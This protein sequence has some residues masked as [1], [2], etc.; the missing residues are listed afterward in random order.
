MIIFH[1]Q[2]KTIGWNKIANYVKGRCQKIDR[3]LPIVGMETC[4]IVQYYT[5]WWYIYPSEKYE[6]VNW[7]DEISNIWENK[8]M[9]ETTNQIVRCHF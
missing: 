8:N 7:D 9:F 3:K 2:S 4:Q 5:G 1:V 6:F